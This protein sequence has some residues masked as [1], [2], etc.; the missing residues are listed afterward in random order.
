MGAN[1]AGKRERQARN[2]HKRCMATLQ[3]DGVWLTLK[4]G[5]KIDSRISRSDSP[6]FG[7][8]KTFDYLSPSHRLAP[9]AVPVADSR[10][11]LKTDEGDA[12]VSEPV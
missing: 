9:W 11:S 7:N 6:R 12:N 4:V 8:V 2:Q 3:I 1:R 10:T 5:R